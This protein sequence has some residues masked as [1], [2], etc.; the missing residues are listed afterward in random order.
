[1]NK[2]IIEV[3]DYVNYISNWVDFSLPL[4]HSIINKTVCGCGFT[5]FCLRNNENVILCSPRV[6][7]LENKV[8]QNPQCCYLK[9]A[10]LTPKQKEN[11]GITKDTKEKDAKDILNNYTFSQ[12]LNL[13]TEY[14]NIRIQL[15]ANLGQ[16]Q[17]LKFLVTYDS[18]PVLFKVLQN[19]GIDINNFRVVVDEFQLIFNDSRFKASTE[20]NFLRYLQDCPNVLYLSATPMLEEY[21]EQMDEFSNLPYYEFHWGDRII[22]PN[23]NRIKTDNLEQSALEIIKAYLE[24]N[25]ESRV[26]YKGK[27]VKSKEV[28]FYC[29]N[30]GMITSIIKKAKLTS[31]QVNVIVSQSNTE[32]KIKLSKCGKGFKFGQA[33]LEGKPHKMFTF[34]TSTAYCGMDFYSTNAKTVILSDCNLKTMSVDISLDLPQ[35][36][37][38]QRLDE[39]PFRF[40]AIFFYKTSIKEIPKKD[41]NESIDKK[42]KKTESIIR[43]FNQTS[44]PED[45]NTLRE[46]QKNLVKAYSYL[47]DYAGIDEKTGNLVLNKLVLLSELRAWEVQQLNYRD[48]IS[49][50]GNLGK[51][52]TTIIS[53]NQE[54]IN[55]I[56]STPLFEE[57]MRIICEEYE[58]NPGTDIF[59]YISSEY[60]DY[61]D[62][63]GIKEIKKS[64]YK[65]F[66]LDPK[67]SKVVDSSNDL[68]DSEIYKIFKEGEKFT[69][70]DIKTKIGDILRN[71]NITSITPKASMIKKYFEV[72]RV[73]FCQPKDENGIIKKIDGYELLNKLD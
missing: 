55:K 67:V 49:V 23:I 42:T 51:I 37:G 56:L 26:N 35:I 24:G 66:R 63:I 22:K 21:L 52:G 31:D 59:N 33:P 18:L 72:K 69:L 27:L 32:N 10:S 39:N 25:T 60:R 46:N 40:E 8:N 53:K 54:V 15:S 68:L 2:T 57:R 29:N 38:R 3:P 48:D 61:I 9:S 19:L 41:L 70:S 20:L 28:V 50:L 7:L 73:S 71:L 45:K 1:M 14:L 12:S 11:L 62:T 64:N 43:I 4:G 34:C 36:I 30:V 5:E 44:N 16:S 65:K 17:P 6:T 47:D 58:K 13:V